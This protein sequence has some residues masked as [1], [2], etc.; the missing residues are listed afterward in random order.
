MSNENCMPCPFCGGKAK[1][2]KA[3]QLWFAACA[4]DMECHFGPIDPPCQTEDVA[5]KVW[6]KR[7]PPND[8]VE[9]PGN[10]VRSDAELAGRPT[11]EP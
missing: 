3:G 4:E 2:Y 8:Q 6:N 9:R 5:I 7:L 11:S 10:P 1:T